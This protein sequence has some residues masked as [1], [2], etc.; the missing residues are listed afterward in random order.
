MKIGLVRHFKVKQSL[1][2]GF[3]IGHDALTDWFAQ[4][5]HAEVNYTT[6]DMRAINWE[7]CYASTMSRAYKTARHIFKGEIEVHDDLREVSVLNLMNKKRRLP[8]ILW[9][10]LIKRKTL[11]AN[12]ITE[13][14]KK[15]LADFVDKL[16][17]KPEK[18]IL[19]VSHGFIMMLLQQE[20]IARGFTGEL[21]RNP[22]NGK[23]YIF[24]KSDF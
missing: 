13:S 17:T 14:T 21:F 5:D 9:A 20:L 16:L 10:I 22:A 2:R 8:I 24:E 11:S 15:K 3:L 18:E 1:P 12:E 23:V 7:L 6:I 4:Y 19:I